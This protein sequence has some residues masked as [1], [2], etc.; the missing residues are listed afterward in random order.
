MTVPRSLYIKGNGTVS[1]FPSCEYGSAVVGA[2]VGAGR[3][4]LALFE[5][6]ELAS[7]GR[8]TEKAHTVPLL[9]SARA[10]SLALAIQQFQ[11]TPIGQASLHRFGCRFRIEARRIVVAANPFY[12]FF[13]LCMRGISDH[14]KKS[15]VS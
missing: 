13:V 3:R 9:E 2:F 12:P 5:R 14:F 1:S 11:L 15:F 7:D 10:N 4:S 8:V 6:S